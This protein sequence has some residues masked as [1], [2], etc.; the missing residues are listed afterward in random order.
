MYVE[1]A[2]HFYLNKSNKKFQ[3]LKN[4]QKLLSNPGT[5]ILKLASNK[6]N[7]SKVIINI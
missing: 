5:E 7:L 6:I 1:D 3:L 2:A 4:A